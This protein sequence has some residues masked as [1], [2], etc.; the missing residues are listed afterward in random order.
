MHAGAEHLGAIRVITDA[1][2]GHLGVDDVL[3][4]ITR[5]VGE[6][7][8]VDTAVVLLR[9]HDS[10]CLVARAAFGIEEEVRQGVQVPI[11]S[12]FAG[13]I[14]VR[15][16]PAVLDQVDKTTVLNPLLWERGLRALMGVPLFDGQTVIGVLH[17]GS[18]APRRFTTEEARSL[19]YVADRVADAVLSRGNEVDRVTAHV[20]QRSLLP[21]RL[22]C[23]PG[24][25]LATRYVPA[26]DGGIG[27]DWYDAF[28]LPTGDLWLT[29]GD[30]VGHGL[31]PAVIMGRL[32]S[33]MRS[34][35]LEGHNPEQVLLLADRKLQFFEEG[36]MATALVA[37]LS[38]PYDRIRL[39]SAGHLPPVL[40]S[41]GEATVVL[42][43]P[44]ST[45]LGVG[46]GAGQ[47]VTSV[48]IDFP[49]GA[50]LVACTDGLIER[51]DKSLDEG[52]DRLAA[53][54]RA[55]EPAAVCRDVMEALVGRRVPRDDIAVVAV[56]RNPRGSEAAQ[57]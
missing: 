49:F 50:T 44:V 38:P 28:C 33:A 40:A 41:P 17:V 13:A 11:G 56:H 25:S 1:Y 51:R 43:I 16:E 18:L 30:V 53:A 8:E 55:D 26:E 4:E 21:S 57:V 47:P 32:R 23:C 54:V 2:L 42:E 52:M 15:G 35:V 37:V 19:Q 3:R 9:D 46:V 22:P 36:A 39:A 34:Y 27:G 45:P 29:I 5:R 12:G 7:L 31:V 10:D 14:A 48:C 24:L 20:L 6:L